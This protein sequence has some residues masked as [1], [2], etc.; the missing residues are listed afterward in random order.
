MQYKSKGTN[1]F[2]KREYIFINDLKRLGSR[3]A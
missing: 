3:V 2:L 1:K